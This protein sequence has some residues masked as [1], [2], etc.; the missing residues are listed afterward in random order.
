M[1][2]QDTLFASILADKRKFVFFL[3][4]D[5]TLSPIETKPPAMIQPLMKQVLEVIMKDFQVIILSGRSQEDLRNL[6][7]IENLFYAG[8]YGI[9][10]SGPQGF[11]RVNQAAEK[12]IPWTS[13]MLFSLRQKLGNIPDLVIEDRIYDIV[14]H[15]GSVADEAVRN[16]I[17]EVMHAA[18]NHLLLFGST[19][20]EI[21]PEEWDKGKA[22]T[23]L[24]DIFGFSEE[25]NACI[26]IGDGLADEPAFE[27]VAGIGYGILVAENDRPTKAGYRLSSPDEVR[28]FLDQFKLYFCKMPSRDLPTKSITS[29]P[30]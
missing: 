19:S 24:M 18:S 16:K 17:V 26:F 25:T 22:V 2:L 1:N 13:G 15:Y 5:G 21:L 29:G 7:G 8:N 4:Y 12:I 28:C 23:W 6:I 20:G 30:F 11:S 3:D 9:E 10:L 14:L 27:A